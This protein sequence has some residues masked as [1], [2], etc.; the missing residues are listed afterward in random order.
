MDTVCLQM[1]DKLAPVGDCGDVCVEGDEDNYGVV[2]VNSGHICCSTC[3]YGRHSCCH[4]SYVSTMINEP[5]SEDL[6]PA[7]QKLC[8]LISDLERNSKPVY[9]PTCLSSSRIPFDVP[10][11]VQPV[12]H[13]SDIDRFNLNDGVAKLIPACEPSCTLCKRS[14]WSEDLCT[15]CAYYLITPT[16]IIPAESEIV[17]KP[18]LLSFFAVNA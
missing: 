2:Y 7:L 14:N 5:N 16:R 18:L 11:S 17:N 12:F 8:S 13:Q 10:A 1:V 15:T 4:V 9:K 6:H 3:K